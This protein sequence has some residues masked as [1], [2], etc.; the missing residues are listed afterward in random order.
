M[1]LGLSCGAFFSLEP[2]INARL[3]LRGILVVPVE[4]LLA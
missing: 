1:I 4:M 3:H 2:K